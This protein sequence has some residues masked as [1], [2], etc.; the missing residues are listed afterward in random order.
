MEYIREIST[1]HG[2]YPS[3]PRNH[4]AKLSP[5]ELG[6]NEAS[7]WLVR[8]QPSLLSH[9]SQ[10]ADLARRV[11][12]ASGLQLKHLTTISQSISSQSFLQSTNYDKW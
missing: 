2:R 8:L 5:Y 1:I 10:L 9:S 7:A 4:N 6:V 3:G 11:V 12:A